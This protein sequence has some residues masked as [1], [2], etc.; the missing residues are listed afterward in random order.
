MNIHLRQAYATIDHTSMFYIVFISSKTNKHKF[1]YGVCKHGQKQQKLNF[2]RRNGWRCRYLIATLPAK[3]C[4]QNRTDFYLVRSQFDTNHHIHFSTSTLPV[5]WTARFLRL[6][7]VFLRQK[8]QKEFCITTVAIFR[9][10][11]YAAVFPQMSPPPPTKNCA[12]LRT[13][14]HD[15]AQWSI[16]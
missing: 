8:N 6:S 16:L 12:R 3:I 5:L 7:L 1:C 14:S 15:Y 2:S 9:C 4:P 11:L 10:D 13:T